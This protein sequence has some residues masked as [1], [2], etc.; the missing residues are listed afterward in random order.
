MIKVTK[1]LVKSFLAN[2]D[3]MQSKRVYVGVPGEYASRGAVG[4]INNATIGY[5]SERGSPVNNIPARPHLVP[6]VASVQEKCAQELKLG[7]V[8]ALKD[9]GAFDT[10]LER[11]GLIAQTAVKKKIVSQ[12]GFAE[13]SPRTLR[14]RKKKGF[15]G[16][17][18]LIESGQYLNAINYVVR[19]K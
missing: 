8:A 10:R 5:I 7:A 11:V 14:A 13:L 12:E 6:G 15:K 19:K 17:K 16:T 18:A 9:P 1:D 3:S 4:P 2:I